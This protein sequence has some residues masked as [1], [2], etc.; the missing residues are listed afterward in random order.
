MGGWSSELRATFPI[1]VRCRV[2]IYFLMLVISK[3]L[4]LTVS[5]VMCCSFNSSIL[6]TSM[7]RMLQCRKTSSFFMR[8]VQSAQLSHPHSSKLMGMAR[9][10]R[11]LLQLSTLS[12]IHNLAM[13]PIDVLTDARRVSIS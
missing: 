1:K 4:F 2:A 3:N 7:L 13:D 6:M 10:M 11:Y 12:S 5:F 9:K 8:D